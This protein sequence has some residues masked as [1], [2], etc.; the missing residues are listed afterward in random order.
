MHN[1]YTPPPKSH[2]VYIYDKDFHLYGAITNYLSFTIERVLAGIGSFS[3]EIPISSFFNSPQIGKTILQAI[4]PNNIVCLGKD[5]ARAG[6]IDK[7][8]IQSG[9]TSKLV[10][11]GQT[12]KSMA[13]WRII[14]PLTTIDD[15]E[16]DGWEK[17][18]APC[19]EALR[20]FFNRHCIETVTPERKIP[21]LAMEEPATP[22]RGDE[23]RWYA[24]HDKMLDDILKAICEVYG[25]GW[26]IRFDINS[27]RYVFVVIE[28]RD[29]TMGKRPSIVFERDR[30]NLGE[31][32]YTLTNKDQVNVAYIGGAGKYEDQLV[33]P[34]HLDE[35]G[36]EI[37]MLNSGWERREGWINAGN[38][39]DPEELIFEGLYRL[40]SKRKPNQSAEAVVYNTQPFIYGRDWDLGDKVTVL[41]EDA[42]KI[43]RQWNTQITKVVE[44]YKDNML[45]PE[46]MFGKEQPDIKKLLEV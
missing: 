23:I 18:I 2:E 12:I 20:Y 9:S 45:I 17:I 32:T 19:E 8:E 22:Y 31:Y 30:D 41:F 7:V 1:I 42:L 38:I 46:P 13:S 11:S 36:Q 28:P 37:D 14:E 25:F 44:T 16:A 24:G 27:K 34:A 33:L 35:E 4:K 15:P 6:I 29:R 39:S 21:R 3:W 10:V 40:N 43:K 5:D 26:D